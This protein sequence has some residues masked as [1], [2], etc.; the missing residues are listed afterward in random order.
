MD[1]YI[2]SFPSIAETIETFNQTKNTVD[3]ERQE[4]TLD[5]TRI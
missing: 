4:D 2:H 1:D 5:H 3:S